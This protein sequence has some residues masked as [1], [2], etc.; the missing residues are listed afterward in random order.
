MASKTPLI[1]LPSNCKRSAID[2]FVFHG[3]SITLCRSAKIQF[4]EPNRL[5]RQPTGSEQA[6]KNNKTDSD[7][8]FDVVF[9][10]HF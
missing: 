6:D 1:G 9:D 5:S 8:Y 3:H 7:L 4:V 2:R 10:I